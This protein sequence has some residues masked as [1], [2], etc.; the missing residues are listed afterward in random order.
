MA[1]VPA[2][3]VCVSPAVDVYTACAPTPTR[4]TPAILIAP[5]AAKFLILNSFISFDLPL[6]DWLNVYLKQV[7]VSPFAP[8]GLGDQMWPV[9]QN[10][11]ICSR[12]VPKVEFPVDAEQ[13]GRVEMPRL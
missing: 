10:V 9:D 1:S 11:T 5:I 3:I 6:I 4:P 2:L 7:M 12:G 13:T 8:H